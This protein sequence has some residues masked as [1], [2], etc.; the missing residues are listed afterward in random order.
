MSGIFNIVTSRSEFFQLLDTAITKTQEFIA[1][2]PTWEMLQAIARQLQAMKQWTAN[3]RK[4]SFD[5]RQTI[6]MGTTV[7]RELQGTPELEW[8]D[9]MQLIAEL[10]LYFKYWRTDAGLLTLDENDWRINFPEEH[11]LSDE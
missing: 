1:Q 6:S 2:N 9:Y 10:D 3:G 5:E 7:Q 8:Y 4:P 11:D